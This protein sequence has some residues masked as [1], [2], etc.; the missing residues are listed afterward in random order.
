MTVYFMSATGRNN[1]MFM[2]RRNQL[3]VLRMT[4]MYDSNEK[5]CRKVN[6]VN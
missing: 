1:I 6:A 3:I 5:A 4:F 2:M